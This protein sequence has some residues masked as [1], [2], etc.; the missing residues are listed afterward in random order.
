MLDDLTPFLLSHLCQTL[1]FF[2][3]EIGLSRVDN[4]ASIPVS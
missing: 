3:S 2:I 4:V 1:Y